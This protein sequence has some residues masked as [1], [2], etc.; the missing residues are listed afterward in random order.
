MHLG[1]IFSGQEIEE[2]FKDLDKDQDGK[3][4][5]KE[6]IDMILPNDFY[7]ESKLLNDVK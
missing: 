6:F 5:L 4:N 1:A 7:I 3:L 2:T